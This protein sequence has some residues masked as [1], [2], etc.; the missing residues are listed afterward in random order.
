MTK[1]ISRK[2]VPRIQGTNC[3]EVFAKRFKDSGEREKLQNCAKRTL[4]TTK[5]DF[6][7]KWGN[8]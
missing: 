4:K 5:Y 3:M 6:V 1:D 7:Y 2:I 8:F